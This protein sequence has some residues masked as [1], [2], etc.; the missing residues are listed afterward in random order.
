MLTTNKALVLPTKK[1]WCA[2]TSQETLLDNYGSRDFQ[3]KQ[4]F[5][6]YG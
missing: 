5:Q 3:G 4:S 6:S 1:Q 2:T